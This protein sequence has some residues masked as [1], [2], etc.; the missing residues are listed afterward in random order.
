MKDHLLK[1]KTQAQISNQVSVLNCCSYCDR[2][3][4][5][6]N[7]DKSFINIPFLNFVPQ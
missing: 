3:L 4:V 5:N 7:W 1:N 2:S 6:K